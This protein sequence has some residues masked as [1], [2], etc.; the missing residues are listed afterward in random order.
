MI[1]PPVHTIDI[2]AFRYDTE[3]PER[4]EQALKTVYSVDADEDVNL[5]R[6]SVEGHF[7]NQID[8][9]SVRLD[10]ADQIREAMRQLLDR[11]DI[12]EILTDIDDRVTDDCELYLRFDKQLAYTDDQ[13]RLGDGIEVRI[14][15]EAYPANR[16]AA[17]ANARDF[18]EAALED[19]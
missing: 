4:V 17:L 7:G 6:D 8:V 5:M 16:D 3:V 18:F 15:L 14:K 11:A 2:R 13:L 19:A 9:Y 12:D 1:D 10:R